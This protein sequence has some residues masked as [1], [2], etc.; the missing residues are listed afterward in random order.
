MSSKAHADRLAKALEGTELAQAVQSAFSENRIN[1]LCRVGKG[2]EPKW[3]ELVQRMLISTD[4]EA[5]QAHAWQAHFCRHYFLKESDGQKK[6]VFGWNISVQSADMSTSLDFLIRVIKGEEPG[7]RTQQISGQ[8][9]EM[10]LS[11]VTGER[12]AAKVP[13]G[14]G[15]Y[16]VGG[17]NDF[18]PTVGRRG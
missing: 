2:A 9:D 5:K 16:S 11:G 10:P 3:V 13:G 12:N 1:V 18:R 8:V 15:A 4:M 14:K 6:I 7:A 17:R